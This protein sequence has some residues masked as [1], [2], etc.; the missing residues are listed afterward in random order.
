MFSS[1]K[2]KID[3]DLYERAKAYAAAKKYPSVDDFI[4]RLIERELN[5]EVQEDDPEVVKRLQGLGYI[6]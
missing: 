6:E 3:K 4:A 2:I 1:Q 5:T